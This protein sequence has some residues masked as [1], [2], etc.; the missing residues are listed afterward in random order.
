MVL[1]TL[2]GYGKPVVMQIDSIH[3]KVAKN[4]RLFRNT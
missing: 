3:I 2:L 4:S 1:N